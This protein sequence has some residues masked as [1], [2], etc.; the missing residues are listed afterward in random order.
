MQLFESQSEVFER[1]VKEANLEKQTLRK[2]AAEFE[3]ELRVLRNIVANKQ[4]ENK[5]LTLVSE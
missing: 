2:E 4:V 5:N 1:Q 3:S